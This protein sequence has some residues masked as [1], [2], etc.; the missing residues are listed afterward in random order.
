MR[1]TSRRKTPFHAGALALLLAVGVPALVAA[2][3]GTHPL[4]LEEAIARALEKNEDIFIERRAAAAAQAAESGA[5]GAYDPVLALDAGWRETTAPVNSA[6]SG[7]PE[8]ELAP[9]DEVTE[10]GVSVRQLL[11]TGADLTVRASGSR[12][13]TDASF[14]LLAPA[15]NSRLGLELRQPLWRDR[16]IDSARLVVRVTAADREQAQAALRLRVRDTVA[17]VENAYWGLVAARR[18]VEVQS[19]AVELA[20]EQLSE[21]GI[22][23]ESGA[24]PE[25]EIAQP[26]AELE[27]RRGDLL[28]AQETAARAENALKLLV[29]GD[30]ERELWSDSLRPVDDIEPD[31]ETVDLDAALDRALSTRAE[32]ESA[33]AVVARRRVEAT[34]AADRVHPALDLVVSYDR[35]GLAGDLNPAA[36]PIPGLPAPPAEFRGDL[37][38]SWGDIADGDF[39]ETRIGLLFEVPLGN[40]A[41]RA[42][43]E[44]ARHTQAQA[45]A[46]LARLR[47]GVRAEVLD[48]GAALETAAARIEAA[49]AAREAA[50]VQLEAEQERFAAGLSTNF[51]VLTRQNELSAARL[52]ETRALTDYR[53]ARI[54]MARATGALLLERGI[55]MQDADAE[56]SPDA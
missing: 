15:Y 54:E 18:D 22:R 43:A 33:E 27:R 26:R 23:I 36:E 41:A 12:D 3:G 49:R 56:A 45:E 1:S 10:A 8:G 34:F 32:L 9:T 44:I 38:D 5:R 37:Q 17:A 39:D 4:T 19:E 2:S 7:A 6:F 30:E 48:A 55:E 46:A 42:D 35:F 25:T 53:T 14:D 21:T 31:V 40:R 47:K 24:A 51:L 50:E 11:S 20:E 13:D 28:Q 52:N 16:A 29:L